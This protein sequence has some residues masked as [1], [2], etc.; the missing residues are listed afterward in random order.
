MSRRSASRADR[1][2]AVAA[3]LQPQSHGRHHR[4]LPLVDHRRGQPDLLA[5]LPDQPRR[6]RAGAVGR[7]LRLPAHRARLRGHRSDDRHRH[8][9]R[10]PRQEVHHR[11][12]RRAR[13]D[14]PRSHDAARPQLLAQGP[15]PGERP[16]VVEGDTSEELWALR[17]VDFEI[18]RGELVSIIGHNGAGKT[19]AAQDPVA[20]HRADQGPGRDPRP[21][22]QPA[23]GRH[24]L[25]SRA[26]RAREHLP[27]RRDPRHDAGRGAGPF[28]G[29]RRLLGR[30]QVHR[31]AGEALLGRHV[32]PS[33]LCRGG[34]SRGRD[35]GDRRGAGGGR[36]RVPGALPRPHVGGGN[37]RP[38][39]PVRQ[40]QPR[41]RHR[42]DQ[43]RHRLP[44]RPAHLRR[45]GRSRLSRTIPRRS[46]GPASAATGAAAG[47]RP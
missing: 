43:A 7:H 44:V 1:A 27:E 11:P 16:A 29:D 3:A 34:A 42:T 39:R 14:V 36:C 46:A 13:H 40:P 45:P 32:C 24:R 35:P 21:G 30:A 47:R 17:D 28:R 33:R 22:H 9:R 6:H 18:K 23:R 37:Q 2:R 31:H 8:P 12:S 5:G 26:D 20:H 25:P 38:H 41:R 19:H 15:R 10:E 4:R